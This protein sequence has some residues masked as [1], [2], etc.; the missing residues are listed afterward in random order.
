[1][2][3]GPRKAGHWQTRESTEA[4][5]DVSQKPLSPEVLLLVL[6]S[7]RCATGTRNSLPAPVPC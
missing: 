6:A 5:P 2:S 4:A 3:C 7:Q 1:M